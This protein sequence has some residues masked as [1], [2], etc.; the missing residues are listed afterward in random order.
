MIWLETLL[1]YFE[2]LYTEILNLVFKT[3]TVLW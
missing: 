1:Y 2:K 3:I